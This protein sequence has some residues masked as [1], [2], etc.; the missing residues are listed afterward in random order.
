MH[1][2]QAGIMR[3]K[4]NDQNGFFG[5]VCRIFENTDYNITRIKFGDFEI[6]RDD[7]EQGLDFAGWMIKH[8]YART[9]AESLQNPLISITELEKTSDEAEKKKAEDD[10]KP[11]SDGG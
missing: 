10:A 9:N 2:N 6:T 8:G 11:A 5:S 1:I 3:S 7:Y 4:L